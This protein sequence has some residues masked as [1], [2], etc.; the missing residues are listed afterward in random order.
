MSATNND[1]LVVLTRNEQQVYIE[2]LKRK[3][4]TIK[5][6]NE[7]TKNYETS[8]TV[9]SRLVKKGYAIRA[10][11]GYYV[12][13]PPEL[14][15]F[16][17]E[18]DRYILAYRVGKSEGVLSHHT[19]L[20][21][22][23]VAQSY[24]NTVFISRASPLR[25]FEFQGI[26]YRFI[27]QSMDFGKSTIVRDG[28]K[29]ELTDRERTILDCIRCPDYCGGI[30]ELVKSISTFHTIDLDTM[31]KYIHQYNERSLAIKTGYL[32]SLLKEE[33]RIPEKFLEKLRARKK[34]KIYYLSPQARNGEGRLIKE[35]NLIVPKTME[36]VMRFA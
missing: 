30:E 2:M 18:V 22:H 11:R 3:V 25:T 23:G 15:G 29:V 35:W 32:L 16:N 12:A 6:I 26:E 1:K 36:E 28:V 4:S 20:E 8:R 27:R 10:H 7:T 13:V 14:L 19:A 21:L 31:G 5:E 33:L 9:L 24:F 17:Y 34:E